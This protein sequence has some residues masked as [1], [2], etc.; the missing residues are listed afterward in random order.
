M[1]RRRRDVKR[2]SNVGARKKSTDR[3][4]RSV[5]MKDSNR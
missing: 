3:K 2:R 5:R 4:R 1:K